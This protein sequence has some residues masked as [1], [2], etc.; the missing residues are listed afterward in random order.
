M[1]CSILSSNECT[2]PISGST[3]VITGEMVSF[4]TD[5][6][7]ACPSQI[8][9]ASIW[10]SSSISAASIFFDDV[11]VGCLLLGAFF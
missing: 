10:N 9:P 6:S 4:A 7:G 11:V 5:S 3:G 2:V 1:Y 8:E